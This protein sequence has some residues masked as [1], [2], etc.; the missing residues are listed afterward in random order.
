ME[1]ASRAQS[2]GRR[3]RHSCRA[4]GFLVGR[5]QNLISYVRET[6]HL[7]A[8]TG[9]QRRQ[10]FSRQGEELQIT[11]HLVPKSVYGGDLIAVKISM[12]TELERFVPAEWSKKE[13]RSRAREIERDR[14]RADVMN[15]ESSFSSLTALLSSEH[16]LQSTGL[17]LLLLLMNPW[18]R[19]PSIILKM[20]AIICK[21]CRLKT[22]KLLRV[23]LIFNISDVFCYTT[24]FPDVLAQTRRGRYIRGQVLLFPKYINKSL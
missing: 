15:K 20:T 19:L 2:R 12:G 17:R 3:R 4:N 23:I 22:W 9:P 13:G 6:A 1:T 11:T 7:R 5:E 10:G 16:S 8:P 18:S 14:G 21:K 24:V